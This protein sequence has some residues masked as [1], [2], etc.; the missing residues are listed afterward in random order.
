MTGPS[1]AKHE[2]DLQKLESHLEDVRNSTVAKEAEYRNQ[3]LDLSTQVKEMG[4]KFNSLAT[5]MRTDKM[6]LTT[7][8]R[9]LLE[10]VKL[11]HQGNTTSPSSALRN[12]SSSTNIHVTPPKTSPPHVQMGVNIPPKTTLS[13]SPLFMTTAPIYTQTPPISFVPNSTP[14]FPYTQTHYTTAQTQQPI[15]QPT[16]LGRPPLTAPTFPN[17]TIN[18][19]Q[20]HPPYTNSGDSQF[21]RSSFMT[22]YKLPKVEF[23]KFD[24][25]NARGWVVKANKFFM[26]NPGMDTYTKIV[27]ASLYLEGPADHWFQTIQLEQPDLTWETLVDL[28]LQRFSSGNQEN[29]VGRFN[30]L[31]QKGTVAEYIAEF[32]ELRVMCLPTIMCIHLISICPVF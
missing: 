13:P 17:Q 22:P 5:E 4:R 31:V 8:I 11:Q 2:K 25:I 15:T 30:K 27:F 21:H 1:L 32:E 14:I 10:T 6:D 23:P 28:L 24:G 29:L 12:S 9:D 16:P 20:Y 18:H 7:Q 3:M 26:L 19:H